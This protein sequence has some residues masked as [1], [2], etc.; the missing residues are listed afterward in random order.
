MIRLK[1]EKWCIKISQI[2][3]AYFYGFLIIDLVN[4]FLLNAFNDQLPI[5]LGQ[6]VRG[7]LTSILIFELV[8]TKITTKNNRHIFM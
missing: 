2:I 6:I 7:I 5:S 1:N 8:S 3:L 4:G